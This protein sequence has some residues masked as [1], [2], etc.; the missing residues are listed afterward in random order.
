MFVSKRYSGWVMLKQIK[1]RNQSEGS[2]C[3]LKIEL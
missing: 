3:N 1:D 2:A